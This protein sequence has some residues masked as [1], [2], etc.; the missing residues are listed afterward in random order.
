MKTL[1]LECNMGAAGDML[2]SALSEIHPDTDGFMERLNKLGIPGVVF[3]RKRVVKSGITG[4]HIDVNVNGMHED[5]NIHHHTHN[6]GDGHKHHHH[7]HRG[8]PEIEHIIGH[9]NLPENIKKD[10]VSVFR[11]VAEAESKVHGQDITEIHFHEVGTMDAVADV[12]AVCMLLDEI[13]PDRIIASPVHVGS[14]QVQCAH[15]ILPV[16]AP[17]T[18][19]ILEG[20]PVYGGEVKGELCTPTGAALLKYFANEFGNMP[21]MKI[22]RTGYG[23]GTKDF[24]VANCLRA[25]IGE[26][27]TE[28]ADITGLY[29]NIDD[30]TGEEIAF[31]TEYLMAHGALDVYTIAAGMKK[32]RP[33][34]LLAC[35][36]REEKKQEM[37]GILF[38]YTTTT[39]VRENVFR[40]YELGRRIE[41]VSTKYGGIRV[42]VSEGSGVTK[43]K[44]EYEDV[45][46]KA[47][48]NNVNLWEIKAG[49]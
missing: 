17:A 24:E 33:G 10:V 4:T 31:A 21:L 30:M 46:G 49:L 13:K 5:G 45:A 39:G 16:P 44:P 37:I 6:N 8:I 9:L 25:M 3:E 47:R 43:R 34:I 48:E 27:E 40:R 14:G 19:L 7:Y 15:G 28:P 26:T 41:N 2:M 32:N 42:K 38:K 20:I 35:L 23:M 12:T 1:Y 22:S 18:A 29:C 11:L 36:C